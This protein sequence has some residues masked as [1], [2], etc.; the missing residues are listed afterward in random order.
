MSVL[1]IGRVTKIV[2]RSRG[3]DVGILRQKQS[4]AAVDVE[5]KLF[6]V[7]A[8]REIMA[9]AKSGE[10]TNNS[11][12]ALEGESQ[13][14]A[15]F[16]SELTKLAVRNAV[17]PLVPEVIKSIE[18][19]QWEGPDRQGRRQQSLRQRRAGFGPRGR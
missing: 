4:L 14:S 1:V 17:A 2:F 19:M 11:L 8:G 16:R 12:V 7:A 18:K 9:V 3:D 13:E 10:A 6:D 15:E 5:I